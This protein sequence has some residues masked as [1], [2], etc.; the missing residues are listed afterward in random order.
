MSDYAEKNENSIPFIFVDEEQA[1]DHSYTWLLLPRNAANKKE[2]LP[3]M[4][5]K[6]VRLFGI[7]ADF[8]LTR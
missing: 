8:R 5:M 4:W 7:V 6:D 3:G 2:S 1:H